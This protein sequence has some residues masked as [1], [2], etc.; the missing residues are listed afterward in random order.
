MST[1][2]VPVPFSNAD[3]SAELKKHAAIVHTS[4][5]LS[6]LERKLVNVLLLNAYTNL[7]T[8]KTHQIPVAFL[9]SMVGWDESHNFAKLKEALNRILVTKV[10]LN[11]LGNAGKTVWS[12]TTLLAG[13]K[14]DGSVCTYEYSNDMS[15]LLYAPEMYATINMAVQ[16]EFRGGYALTLYENC[17]RF[18]K[19]GKTPAFEIGRLRKL[20]G[21][22]APM[23]DDFKRFSSFVIKKSVAEIN[24]VADIQIVPNYLRAN[25]SVTAIEFIITESAQQSLPLPSEVFDG[26]HEITKTPL[27]ERL[28]AHGIGEV[29]VL[30]LIK[31]DPERAL[32][33]VNRADKDK[34]ITSKSGYIIKAMEEKYEL[35]KTPYALQAEVAEKEAAV[36]AQSLSQQERIDELRQEFL[37]TQVTLKIKALTSEERAKHLLAYLSSE[38]GLRRSKSFDA[39]EQRFKDSVERLH[40]ENAYLRIAIKAG[41][42]SSEADFRNWLA[43][44]KNINPKKL[45]L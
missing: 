1:A 26:S 12:S 38:E 30:Q 45:G 31:Q 34:K 24:R 42:Q 17:I 3:S 23:Y 6:L 29:L 36:T 21:A 37:R 25:R 44:E 19:L 10:E 15:G 32:A 13:V 40:F 7:P 28:R 8:S 11:I 33:A 22:D 43:A 18:R 9:S 20:L 5:Q 35:G 16:K 2:D 4:G 39:K 14:I 41:V 27:Y